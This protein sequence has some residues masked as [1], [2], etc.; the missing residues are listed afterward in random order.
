MNSTSAAGEHAVVA[1]EAAAA[2]APTAACID[3]S[4]RVGDDCAA[5]A[6]VEGCAA[7]VEG[8]AECLTALEINAQTKLMTSDTATRSRAKLES[9]TSAGKWRCCGASNSLT[10]DCRISARRLRHLR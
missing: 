7:E 4:L 2:A 3:F 8:D 6:K 10:T 5:A 1:A 9:T